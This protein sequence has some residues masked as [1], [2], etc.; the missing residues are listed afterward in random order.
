MKKILLIVAFVLLA[1]YGVLSNY[2]PNTEINKYDS[3]ETVKE[4]K[5]IE[6]GWVPKILPLSAYNIVETH[7]VDG[8]TIFGKFNYKEMDEIIFLSKLKA[9]NEMYE[10]KNFLFK[11]D[12]EKNIV[13]FRNKP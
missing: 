4:N 10:S 13:N 2:F 5:G 6:K 9:S 7:D 3:I 8:N 12:K 1:I 11:V